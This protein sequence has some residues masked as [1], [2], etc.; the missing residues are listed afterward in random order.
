M[1]VP[2]FIVL[3]LAILAG[4]IHAADTPPAPGLSVAPS[5]IAISPDC[6]VA[7]IEECA[8]PA[9]TTL[10][11]TYTVEAPRMERWG[12]LVVNVGEKIDGRLL[13]RKRFTWA[14]L[15]SG[16]PQGPEYV[17]ART[18]RPT[19]SASVHMVFSEDG[20][21]AAMVLVSGGLLQ[22]DTIQVRLGDTGAGGPG[23]R[24]PGLPSKQM[25]LVRE[26]LDGISPFERL[27]V[28]Y[29]MPLPRVETH[30]GQA[31]QFMVSLPSEAVIG[32]AIP[33]TVRAMAGREGMD[34]SSVPVR[35]H[36][37]PLVLEAS[38]PL[39]EIPDE[40]S[41]SG[42]ERGVLMVPVVFHT[43]GLHRIQAGE[44]LP[45]SGV[46]G[47]GPAGI[48]NPVLVTRRPAELRTL[49]GQL[50]VHSG[51]SHDGSGR[52]EDAFLAARDE[53]GYDFLAVTDH[54][55]SPGYNFY[56]AARI[57]D[58][59]DEPGRF[60]AF[61]GYE[62]TAPM[63]HR[64]VIFADST[65]E[66]AACEV[67]GP[68]VTG[69]ILAPELEDIDREAQARRALLVVHHPLWNGPWDNTF[70][71]FTLG[72]PAE[73]TATQRLLEI[74]S[75]H[76][77]SEFYDNEPYVI[78]GNRDEQQPPSVPASYQDA[79]RLGF[80]LGVVAGS[81]NH[82][83]QADSWTGFTLGPDNRRY[84]RK[85]I[86]AVLAGE[87]S[88]D[89]IF[90]AF[91]DGR[92]YAT[93]GARTRLR[94]TGNGSPMG[95][96]VR[97]GRAVMIRVEVAGTAPLDEIVLIRNGG[98]L[99]TAWTVLPETRDACVVF[100]DHLHDD[101]AT[102]YYVRV[103]QADDHLAWSSPLWYEFSPDSQ[104][105]PWPGGGAGSGRDSGVKVQSCAGGQ[106]GSRQVSPDR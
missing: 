65:A 86:T 47:S 27:D 90:A 53:T 83:A 79:L 87:V 96:R 17:T 14:E 15:Q 57:A 11:V 74:H 44:D 81:D 36:Q 49:W 84:S 7:R 20:G 26:S 76:G 32:E 95:S 62:W 100:R 28:R 21:T 51:R 22:G 69:V 34:A 1:R 97:S 12:G 13:S 39:A 64:Q 61:R 103:R 23:M 70:D 31:D 59:F 16:K 46:G 19:V 48:S 75:Q 89:A 41:F 55:N 2:A 92:T 9:Y 33:V 10:V 77:R 37:G 98:E 4:A 35:D 42:A 54:C 24:V 88:R 29:G 94:V 101:A 93:T 106:P 68:D 73:P 6:A 58:S 40:V 104:R 8:A 5:L 3:S 60:T 56:T 25:V 82:Q 50:H 45:S 38:D 43:P 72:D 66:T 30:G 67:L 78:H 99:E 80:R 52:T 71:D 18:S 63:G 105:S 91:Q 85:G 102:S